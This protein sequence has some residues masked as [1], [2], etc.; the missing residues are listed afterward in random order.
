M[1]YRWYLPTV[2]VECQE[3]GYQADVKDGKTPKSCPNCGWTDR[4]Q[5][6]FER[7]MASKG[8]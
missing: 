6:D 4:K 8:H 3:C 7:K 2:V 1:K 5:A